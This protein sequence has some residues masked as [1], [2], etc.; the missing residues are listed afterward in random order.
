[1]RVIVSPALEVVYTGELARVTGELLVSEAEVVLDDEQEPGVVLPSEDV[2]FVDRAPEHEAE[3]VEE[4]PLPVSAHVRVILGN[5]VRLTGPGVE[6]RL[7]G[8]LL[9]LQEPGATARAVG[10]IR[11]VEG[12]YAAYGQRLQIESGRLYFAGGPVDNPAIDL[13]AYRLAGDGVRAGIEVG[14]TLE[15]PEVALWSDPDLPET[16]QLSYVMLGRRFDDAS[17]SDGDLLTKAATGLGLK[18]GRLLG[19]RV[20]STLGLEEVTVEAEDGYED[21]SLVL[22]KYLSPELYVSYGIGLFEPVNVFRIRYLVSDHWTLQAETGDGTSGD[23]VYT[24][25]RGPGGREEPARDGS[26]PEAAA[27]PAVTGDSGAD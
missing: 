27:G 14:G 10:E 17:R 11:I 6:A 18:G 15:R 9:V 22:G 8:S 21:A 23:V 26:D 5:E 1:M 7:G 4:R 19:E 16:D 13:R 25:E 12:S 24:V 2:V 20:A 3:R